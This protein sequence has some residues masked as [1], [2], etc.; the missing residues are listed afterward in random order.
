MRRRRIIQV[1]LFAGAVLVV[2][3][4]VRLRPLAFDSAAW[5][6][7]AGDYRSIT[8]YRM[9]ESA[10]K[11]I[12]DS[13]VKSQADALQYFGPSDRGTAADSRWLYRLGQQFI[14]VDSWWL[15]IHFDEHGTVA[16]YDIRAD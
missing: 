14:P 13:V 6:L 7:A 4:W 12:A 5:K 3:G 15:D 10:R 2:A 8:R 16:A 11:L 9:R 1:V